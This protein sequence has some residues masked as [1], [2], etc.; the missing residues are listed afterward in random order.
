M[1]NDDTSW[2]K[3]NNHL[4]GHW[5]GETQGFDSPAHIW[6]ITHQGER[7][8]VDTRWENETSH[9]RLYGQLVPG[10]PAFITGN[11]KCYLVDSQ[12]F[13]VPGWDTND[14]RGGEGPD[15]DV[16]FSRPGIAELT[17]HEV[18]LRRRPDIDRGAEPTD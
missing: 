6:H 16:V 1:A 11:H 17:A 13:I 9:T 10:E 14:V 7:L 12:H 2:H 8:I 3:P 4:S 5:I 15:Y 18:W